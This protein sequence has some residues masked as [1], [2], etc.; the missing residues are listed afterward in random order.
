ML[1]HAYSNGDAIRTGR[2]F[3]KYMAEHTVPRTYT[4]PQTGRNL[5]R[6]LAETG[7]RLQRVASG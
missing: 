6:P 3:K 4:A 2:F 7:T 1:Q 5:A